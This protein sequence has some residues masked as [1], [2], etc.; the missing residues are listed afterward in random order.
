V[1]LLRCGG[2]TVDQEIIQSLIALGVIV[3]GCLGTLV[4]MWINHLATELAQNTRITTQARDASNGQLSSVID[5]LAAARNTVMGLRSVV[6]ERDDRLAYITSRLPEAD[7][8]MK[9]F[10]ERRF[11]RPSAT[12]EALAEQHA[13]TSDTESGS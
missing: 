13:L 12:D 4:K 3:I 10:A 7:V 5:Q 6:Q 9:E 2:G 8:L 1:V 11:Y